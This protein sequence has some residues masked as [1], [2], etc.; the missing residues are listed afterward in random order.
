MGTGD[1]ETSVSEDSIADEQGWKEQLT[2]NLRMQASDAFKP[3]P[4]TAAELEMEEADDLKK[5]K[6]FPSK[7]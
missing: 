5:E 2:I 6:R 3:I 1:V 4:L 7:S